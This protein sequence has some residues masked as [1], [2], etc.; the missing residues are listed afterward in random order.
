VVS[1]YCLL[2]CLTCA[3]VSFAEQADETISNDS[4]AEIRRR[5]DPSVDRNITFPSAETVPKGY[6]AINSYELLG[7][8]V[9]FGITDNFQLS[10]SAVL[11]FL[12]VAAF[13]PS[14]KW[15]FLRSD[16]IIMSVQGGAVLASASGGGGFNALG[17]GL[18]LDF[19][20]DQ[21]GTLVLS[22]SNIIYLQKY[23]GSC[24]NCTWE[25]AGYA[26]VPT[27]SLTWKV[28]RN[29]KFLT[30]FLAFFPIAGFDAFDA[31]YA[32]EKTVETFYYFNYGV[33]LFG[34]TVALDVTLL[35]EL[36]K[37]KKELVMGIPYVVFS[38]RF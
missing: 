10:L 14:L 9:S 31:D 18:Y 3:P 35:R 19:V 34:K 33:R 23:T 8:G 6:F 38:V 25:Y 22:L 24:A 21:G 16:R 28:R 2:I 15:C 13:G 32:G 36:F 5:Q 27:A 29:I 37:E 12:G 20:L 7:L 11:P 1:C 4:P 30:E 17:L 26:T